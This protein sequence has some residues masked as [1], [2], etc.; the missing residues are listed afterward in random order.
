MKIEKSTSSF[1]PPSAG[2]SSERARASKST[3]DATPPSAG[4]SVNLGS[5]TSQLRNMDGS[6]ASTPT[7]DAKK[8][9]DIKLAIVQ[10]RFQINS[11]AI[12]DSLIN[13]VNDLISADQT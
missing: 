1:V 6:V 10:G 8:V 2:E 5:T 7:V 3:T 11:A 4:V 13:D 9:A 12:A